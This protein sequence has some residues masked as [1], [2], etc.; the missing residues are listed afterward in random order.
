MKLS[1]SAKAIKNARPKKYKLKLELI[2]AA[3]WGKNLRMLL[4]QDEW[5]VIRR[6]VYQR[7]NYLC[8]VCNG[9][10]EHH[11]VEAH[12][13]WRYNKRKKLQT[14]VRIIALCPECHMVAH[15]GRTI[16]MGDMTIEEVRKRLSKVNK[17]SR[18]QV[19]EHERIMI[20]RYHKRSEIED[21]EIDIS[22]KEEYLK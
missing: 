10:G 9:H 21:W 6:V 1:M 22:K 3:C 7:A 2:P 13:V 15:A 8:Q 18:K 16:H 11:P 19:I 17:W 20:D 4:S 12:E 14:L 5:D